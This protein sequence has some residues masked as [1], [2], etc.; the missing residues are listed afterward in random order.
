MPGTSPQVRW[1]ATLL[2]VAV[3]SVFVIH[4]LARAVHAGVTPFGGY[5][6]SSGFPAGPAIA[7]TLTIVEI[8]GGVAL[9][10]GLL[11]RPLCAWFAAQIATGIAMV[12]GPVGWFVV[13]LGRNGAEYSVLILA[14][15]AA[16]ALTAS[17]SWRLGIGRAAQSPHPTVASGDDEGSASSRV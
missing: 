11:V 16:V 17:A 1:G 9:A 3:A 7:W 8:V 13:G 12:H 14:C 6:S 10:L 4:G 15:L 5:L 2:R